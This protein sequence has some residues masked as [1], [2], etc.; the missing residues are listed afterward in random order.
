MGEEVCYEVNAKLCEVL[1]ERIKETKDSCYEASAKL[2]EVLDERIKE[3]S[4]IKEAYG[5]AT[6]KLD[7]EISGKRTTK[8]EGTYE[9]PTEKLDNVLD[10]I[11]KEIEK[12]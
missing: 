1:D 12:T 3:I 11:I 2:C 7:E 9:K 8:M 4:E 6:E 5:K 10:E